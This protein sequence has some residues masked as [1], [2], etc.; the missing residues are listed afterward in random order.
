MTVHYTGTVRVKDIVPG[1]EGSNPTWATD[2]DGTLFFRATSGGNDYELWKSDGTLTGTVMVKDIR[3]GPAQS[4]IGYLTNVSGTLFF[5]AN[6]GINGIELWKSDGTTGNTVMVKTSDPTT[7]PPGRYLT[8]VAGTLYFSAYDTIMG[9]ELWIS[10]G[11]IQAPSWS[12]I[13]YPEITHRARNLWQVWATGSFSAPLKRRRG[14]SCGS[15]MAPNGHVARPGHQYHRRR[16]GCP[17]TP[18]T[19]NGTL[20]FAADDEV[21]GEELWKSDGTVTG[22]LWS[23]TSAKA[24]TEFCPGIP[25]RI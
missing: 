7:T 10:D 6:D 3:P 11:T 12:K 25:D 23:R 8:N 13:S 1:T 24:L 14:A 15:A 9:S 22:T 16:I 4:S 21:S 20:F 17:T 19:V 2:V 18:S 5:A